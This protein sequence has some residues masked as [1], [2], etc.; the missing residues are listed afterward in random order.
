MIKK[1]LSRKLL[2]TV[3]GSVVVLMTQAGLPA[4]VAAEVTQAVVT[5]VA[6][7]VLGQSAVDVVDKIKAKH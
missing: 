4:E 7:Y 5:I 2:A 6:V 1:F 3:G